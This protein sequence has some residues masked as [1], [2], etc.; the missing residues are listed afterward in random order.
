[1]QQEIQQEMANA[2]QQESMMEQMQSLMSTISTLQTQVN[3][4]NNNN[5]IRGCYDRGQGHRGGCEGC[6]GRR[7][8][9]GRGRGC[10]HGRNG[11][12]LTRQY[13]WTQGNCL[14]HGGTECETKTEG[15]I[16]GATYEIGRTAVTTTVT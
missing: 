15:H 5:Q 12:Q 3:N 8:G 1:M 14:L 13:C 6:G 7:N 11:E 10:G 9:R 16:N 2:T 4:N